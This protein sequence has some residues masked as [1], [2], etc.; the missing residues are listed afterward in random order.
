MLSSL[1]FHSTIAFA[2]AMAYKACVRRLP[3]LLAVAIVVAGNAAPHFLECGTVSVWNTEGFEDC[4]AASLVWRQRARLRRQNFR[5]ENRPEVIFLRTSSP[6]SPVTPVQV[7]RAHSSWNG[8]GDWQVRRVI[9]SHAN[10]DPSSL[11]SAAVM[12]AL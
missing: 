12:A 5:E 11:I 8:T 3:L 2:A 6:A 1:N 7:L 9:S 10:F 4:E